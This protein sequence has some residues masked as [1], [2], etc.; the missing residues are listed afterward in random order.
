MP[1]KAVQQVCWNTQQEIPMP[2]YPLVQTL[3]LFFGIGTS[4]DADWCQCRRSKYP[5]GLGHWH[6]LNGSFL[7]PKNLCGR[8]VQ[9]L[10]FELHLDRTVGLELNKNG[11]VASQFVKEGI[12]GTAA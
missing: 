1:L 11:S 9:G 10:S 7:I 8:V 3:F 12:I 2:L 5:T 6:G 4:G